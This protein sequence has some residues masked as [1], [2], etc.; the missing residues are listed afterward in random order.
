MPISASSFSA[1]LPGLWFTFAYNPD[2]QNPDYSRPRTSFWISLQVAVA[3]RYGM[4]Q[5][6]EYRH[7]R[8]F[9]TPLFTS[10]LLRTAYTSNA[11]DQFFPSTSVCMSEVRARVATPFLAPL[12]SQKFSSESTR[13]RRRHRCGDP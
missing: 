10:N 6:Q 1:S 9:T 13:S 11:Y 8:R 3:A 5:Q 12:I 7:L 2:A 4:T